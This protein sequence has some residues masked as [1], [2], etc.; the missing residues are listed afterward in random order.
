MK[1]LFLASAFF[2]IGLSSFAQD[3]PKELVR[4]ACR[5][6]NA[7][8]DNIPDDGFFIL[9]QVP[10]SQSFGS[11]TKILE[12]REFIR[13]DVFEQY[14]SRFRIHYY[15]RKFT[16]VTPDIVIDLINSDP[17]YHENGYEGVLEKMG[18]NFAFSQNSENIGVT[19]LTWGEVFD[20]VSLQWPGK[21]GGAYRCITLFFENPFKDDAELENE[22]TSNQ[23]TSN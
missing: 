14:S 9:D 21:N 10:T 23:N 2:F 11:Q 13:T 17:K 16:S 15:D 1:T 7:L 22:V 4:L 8:E 12:G 3:Q 18:D 19:A 6:V 5:G 20:E